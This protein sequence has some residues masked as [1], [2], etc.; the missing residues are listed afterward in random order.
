MTTPDTWYAY[1]YVTGSFEPD[2]I[3]RKVGIAPTYAVKVGQP[4]RYIKNAKCSHW[5]LRSRLDVKE[6]LELHVKDVLDQMDANRSA[7]E[8]LSRELG[9]TMELVGYFSEH[10]PGVHFERGIVER[11]A[12]Y[13][14]SIDCDFYNCNRR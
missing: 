4:G 14:L 7:V 10:E 9:G 11:I 13:S 8:A 2:D 3:T 1:F 12:Q 6:E 5:E